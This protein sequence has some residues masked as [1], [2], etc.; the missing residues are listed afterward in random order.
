MLA[1][2]Y[3]TRVGIINHIV[4]ACNLNGDVLV[5]SCE[6]SSQ[7][8]LVNIIRIGR[9][10]I[11][12]GVGFRTTYACCPSVILADL[13]FVF[14]AEF[15]TIDCPYARLFLAKVVIDVPVAFANLTD[16]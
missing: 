15:Q 1:Y 14:L 2:G 5:A 6:C 8:R 3:C 11:G 10:N 16:D 4:R 13:E 9:I 7:L 12:N